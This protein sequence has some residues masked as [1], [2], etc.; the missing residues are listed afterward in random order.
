MERLIVASGGNLRDLFKL[1]ND[2]ASTSELRGAITINADDAHRAI[3]N[4]RSE[5]K[6]CLGESPFDS[7]K[8]TY[9]EKSDL[10]LRIYN[11]DQSAQIANEVTYSL[12]RS[13]A[14]Q[15]FNGER[16]FGV[17]PLVV[18]ILAKQGL[19]PAKGGIPGGVG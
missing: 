11:G 2:A 14:V 6:R 17:H 5:Y 3:V 9:Q 16:W 10:L 13:R 18:D 7:E 8:V 19:I 15:E 4:L 12:L 1:V